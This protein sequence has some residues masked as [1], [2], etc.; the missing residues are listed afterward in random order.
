[1]TQEARQARGR[2]IVPKWLFAW[3]LGR[4]VALVAPGGDD[5]SAGEPVKRPWP[6][7]AAQVTGRRGRAVRLRRAV[8]LWQGEQ[9]L[10]AWP[11]G[12]IAAGERVVVLEVLGWVRGLP[13]LVRVAHR[14]LGVGVVA[15]TPR[16]WAMARGRPTCN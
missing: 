13:D 7:R 16:Y 4:L 14:S 1:M 5:R 9:P 2:V 15:L 6:L 3:L 12:W 11:S 8:P 10:S